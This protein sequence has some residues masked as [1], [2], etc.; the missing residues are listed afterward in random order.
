MALE[1]RRE[2]S[3]IAHSISTHMPVPPPPPRREL[4]DGVLFALA[5]WRLAI[6]AAPFVVVSA[7]IRHAVWLPASAGGAGGPG[8]NLDTSTTS[9]FIGAAVF[10]MAILLNGVMSDFKE[11]EKGERAPARARPASPPAPPAPR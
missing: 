1:V 4:R 3:T 7:Y 8:F 9:G 10:V 6:T 5:R 2:V 11:S